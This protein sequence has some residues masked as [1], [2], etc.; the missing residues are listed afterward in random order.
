MSTESTEGNR[1]AFPGDAP[2]DLCA[3]TAVKY[4]AHAFHRLHRTC[5][6]DPS[7]GA[8]W[9]ADDE[10]VRVMGYQEEWAVEAAP[11]ERQP[12]GN[13]ASSAQSG[14]VHI[15]EYE[16]DAEYGLSQTD[17]YELADAY[18]N[19]DADL[20]DDAWW[21]A[22]ESASRHGQQTFDDIAAQ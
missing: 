17:A 4:D 11:I 16:M 12:P 18:M 13:S 8:E 7:G 2:A 1:E 14:E 19:G 15:I 10:L 6:G 22:S 9:Q 3:L 20:S 5:P 21:V